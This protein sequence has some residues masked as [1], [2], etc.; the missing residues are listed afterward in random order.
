MKVLL[1][2]KPLYVTR[3]LN[4]SKRFEFRKRPFGRTVN[5]VVIY[6][7]SPVMKVVGEFELLGV[8]VGKKDHVWQKCKDFAGVDRALFDA[9]YSG[10]D[11]ACALKVG[12]VVR[13]DKPLDLVNCYGVK[14]PQS[15]CYLPD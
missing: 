2:I 4:G 7:S 15:Y 12:K 11:E 8:L 6:A 9:Y 14:P 1:P 10:R 3:I 13:Y 5:R